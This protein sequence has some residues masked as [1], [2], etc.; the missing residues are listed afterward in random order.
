MINWAQIDRQMRPWGTRLR[1]DLGLSVSQANELA[2]CI[3]REVA[4][5]APLDQERLRDLSPIAVSYRLDEL[6]AFQSWMDI[7]RV[8]LTQR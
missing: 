5:L 8:W 4:A 1:D 6:T 3:S 2:T 7:R